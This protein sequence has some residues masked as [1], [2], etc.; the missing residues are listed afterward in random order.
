MRRHTHT[1][2]ALNPEAYKL[3]ELLNEKI[4]HEYIAPDNLHHLKPSESP[5]L[6]I[7]M[8]QPGAGKSQLLAKSLGAQLFRQHG[9]Y[10]N[11][12]SDIYKKYHPDYETLMLLD[13]TAMTSCTGEDARIWMRQAYQYIKE[14][15]ID[16][17]TQE[18]VTNPPFLIDTLKSFKE[19][20]F[21]VNVF[22]LAVPEAVS[23]QGILARY[24]SQVAEFGYGRL[25]EPGK[26]TQSLTGMSAFI[27]SASA[28]NL[29][30]KISIATRSGKQWNY[31]NTDFKGVSPSQT[32][33]AIRNYPLSQSEIEQFEATD[34]WLTS[35]LNETWREELS[36]VRALGQ[37]LL[38]SCVIME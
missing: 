24:V 9:A 38:K 13:D 8:A 23:R 35:S 3:P 36:I 2:P 27:D 33:E 25:T 16:A 15:R 7:L 21:Q 1:D 17:L 31:D 11:L 34:T 4:F 6:T 14:N 18:I 12:D 20:D 37:P 29:V 32:L 5:T 10:A 26:S 19:H 30:D 28:Q 22:A